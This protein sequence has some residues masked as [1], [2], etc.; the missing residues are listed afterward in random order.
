MNTPHKGFTIAAFAAIITVGLFAADPPA[1]VPASETTPKL[2]LADELVITKLLR[3]IDHD[4]VTIDQAA[5]AQKDQ[6]QAQ[7]ELRAVVARVS[8]TGWHITEP[9]P[10][11][12]Q[13]VKDNADVQPP[14]RVSAP[15]AKP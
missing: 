12:L 15:P 3:R 2:A 1:K 5:V 4:Q 11:D 8:P 13:L 9:T 14:A 10:G 6:Q 7:I